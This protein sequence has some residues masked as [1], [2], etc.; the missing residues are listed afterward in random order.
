MDLLNIVDD[1]KQDMSDLAYKNI[2]EKLQKISI[3]EKEY[4]IDIIY[5]YIELGISDS[6]MVIQTDTIQFKTKLIQNDISHRLKDNYDRLINA[7]DFI[8]FD[9]EFFSELLP[10]NIQILLNKCI[11][12]DNYIRPTNASYD[13]DV[14]IKFPYILVKCKE[15]L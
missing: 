13:N 6:T 2:V 9:L 3:S 4:L 1:H 15:C 11:I 10:E 14:T 5:N 12:V 8:K 7:R